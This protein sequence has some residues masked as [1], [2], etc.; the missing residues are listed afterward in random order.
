MRYTDAVRLHA[1]ISTLKS[2]WNTERNPF[3]TTTEASWITDKLQKPLPIG[4]KVIPDDPETWIAEVPPHT[5][6]KWI[7]EVLKNPA[8]ILAGDFIGDAIIV[9]FR[10]SKDDVIRNI[11]MRR[12]LEVMKFTAKGPHN[13]IHA[14]L[15]NCKIYPILA[16]SK[17]RDFI[18]CL[19]H[20]I[21]GIF[22]DNIRCA[23]SIK[24]EINTVL[25]PKITFIETW[26]RSYPEVFDGYLTDGIYYMRGSCSSPGTDLYRTVQTMISAVVKG[27][28]QSIFENMLEID[29]LRLF[30]ITSY[31]KD[32][33]DGYVSGRDKSVPIAP[34]TMAEARGL[35]GH[36]IEFGEGL[37]S[38]PLPEALRYWPKSVEAPVL[39]Y[40]YS[41]SYKS[42][43]GEQ[44]RRIIAPRGSKPLPAWVEARLALDQ[45]HPLSLAQPKPE[46][47]SSAASPAPEIIP[48]A[49][50]A[51]TSRRERL[52]PR[53]T[54]TAPQTPVA[55]SHHAQAP[56]ITGRT[57]VPRSI[58]GKRAAQYAQYAP[59]PPSPLSAGS[60]RNPT[61]LAPSVLAKTEL[62][63][64]SST[65]IASMI[66]PTDSEFI[67]PPLPHSQSLQKMQGHSAPSL[68]T[69]TAYSIIDR[70][71]KQ[72]S[73]RSP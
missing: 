65:G 27:F 7:A 20:A 14:I 13:V 22:G 3:L 51:S 26:V 52:T 6:R 59:S 36:L 10:S 64:M 60:S 38:S 25:L 9:S 56:K 72:D 17:H 12:V 68:A 1:N 62:P 47:E 67:P 41:D 32:K 16:T 28:S 11:R 15:Y 42:A 53:F 19:S 23:T 71:Q 54:R 45:L 34:D 24:L 4:Y 58:F 35:I 66:P 69:R 21:L 31:S 73:E 49:E 43:L 30:N 46:A 18:R 29:C 57:P 33:H 48:S 70:T 5:E 8:V 40:H 61:P 37:H 44:S 50:K 63:H 39:S 55:E 2:M